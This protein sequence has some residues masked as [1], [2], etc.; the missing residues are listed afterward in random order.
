MLLVSKAVGISGAP[1]DQGEI[2]SIEGVSVLQAIDL[3]KVN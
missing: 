1:D 2:A 3:G